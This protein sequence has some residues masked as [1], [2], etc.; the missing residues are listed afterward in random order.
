M[1]DGEYGKALGTVLGF[2]VVVW[3]SFRA[4]LQVPMSIEP[5]LITHPINKLCVVPRHPQGGIPDPQ[6]N[7]LTA[8]G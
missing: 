5:V 7:L 2:D 6:R 1:N 4:G 8:P 3:V